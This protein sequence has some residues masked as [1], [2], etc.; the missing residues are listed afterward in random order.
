MSDSYVL[1]A[2]GRTPVRSELAGHARVARTQ[3]SPNVYVSTVFLGLDHRWGKQGPPILFETM[4]FGGVEDQYQERYATWDEAEA[5]HAKAV[6]LAQ[7]AL[8]ASFADV[9]AAADGEKAT[10]EQGVKP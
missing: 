10:D 6:A 2:D 7:T 4:I 8:A 1:A 3:V 9:P 5:G